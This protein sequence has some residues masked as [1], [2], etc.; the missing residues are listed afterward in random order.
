V[1]RRLRGHDDDAS[2]DHVPPGSVI[3][4]ERLLPSDVV[5][6]SRRG[7]AAIVVEALAPGSHAALLAREKRIPVVAGPPGV[8]RRLRT[9]DELLVDGHRGTVFVSPDAETPRVP[10]PIRDLRASDRPMPGSMP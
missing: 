10:D 3:V 2:F 7:I 1:I 4:L 5:A 8:V 6:L 9:G